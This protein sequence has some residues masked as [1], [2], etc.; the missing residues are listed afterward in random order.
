MARVNYDLQLKEL[1]NQMLLLGSMIEEVIRKTIHA[2]IT[3]D[4]QEAKQIASGDEKIDAQVRKI[5]QLGY[6]I[7]LRQQPIASDL[8]AVSAAMKMITDM[9]RIGDHGADISEL[10]VLMSKESYPNEIELVKQMSKETSMMLIQAVD[11]FA[12]GNMQ[13]ASA[14]IARDDIVDDVFLQVKNSLANSIKENDTDAMHELDLLMVAKY[15][16]RI[17]DHATN[18]AE[19]VIFSING[20]LP[21]DD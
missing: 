9:E 15:F 21:A 19:W 17:G 6:T 14:V 8:R 5:E 13:K 20:E 12:D 11:A 7:L 10:T 1:K 3:Q 18:I 2:L 4:V 16:E